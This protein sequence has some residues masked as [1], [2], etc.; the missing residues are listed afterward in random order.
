VS[1]GLGICAVL[2]ALAGLRLV[3]SE[4]AARVQ[5]A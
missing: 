2:I 4:S 5:P 1:N 3:R